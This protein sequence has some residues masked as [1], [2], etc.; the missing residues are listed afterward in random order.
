[1][2]KL[3]AWMVRQ[4]N[5]IEE[6]IDELF[7]DFEE[8]KLYKDY[9]RV[10]D[11]MANDEEIMSIINEIK[12][13]QKISANNKDKSVELKINGLYKKLEFYPIYQ[14]YLIMHDEIEEELFMIKEIF[15]KYFMDLL[16]LK[17]FNHYFFLCT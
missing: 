11:K 3:G 2:L 5:D 10:Q 15:D 13:F 14:S 17:Q 9:L 6:K 8:S 7:D 12:K 4:M 16:S 1:M